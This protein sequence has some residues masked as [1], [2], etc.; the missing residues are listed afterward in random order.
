MSSL[1]SKLNKIVSSDKIENLKFTDIQDFSK[2]MKRNIMYKEF[3]RLMSAEEV[4]EKKEGSCHD[5]VML[6][7]YI[8]DKVFP[9]IEKGVLFF[10]EHNDKESKDAATHTLLWYTYR[11]KVYW[12]ENSWNGEEGIHGPF[13][14]LKDLEDEIIRIHSN[15]PSSKRYP[16]LTFSNNGNVLVGMDLNEYVSAFINMNE[17]AFI[18]NE[19]TISEE[20]GTDFSIGD[21]PESDPS[22][23]EDTGNADENDDNKSEEGF[24][25]END[26]NSEEMFN[27]DPSNDTE[28]GESDEIESDS[29]IKPETPSEDKNIQ[30][31]ILKISTLSK[32]LMKN[33]LYNNFNDFQSYLISIHDLLDDN[34]M[35]ISDSDREICLVK[36]GDIQEAVDLY[37]KYKFYI[38][39]YEINLQTYAMFSKKIDDLLNFINSFTKHK[40]KDD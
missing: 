8:F 18:L 20:E 16:M 33:K 4:F 34:R 35:L 23:D 22:S 14:N 21:D 1:Y 25:V 30:P 39:N 2:W 37:I 12:F 19:A 32:A 17:S 7:K 36:L 38:N 31:K 6:E 10:I 40:N 28:S 29:S 13:S 5:Q 26:N 11:D 24:S 27:D 9:E 15:M 3:N